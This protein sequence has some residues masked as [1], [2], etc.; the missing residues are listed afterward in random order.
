MSDIKI[1]VVASDI[2]QSDSCNYDY[3]TIYDGKLFISSF[4]SVWS[5]FVILIVFIT[6]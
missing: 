2:E 6:L 4:V 5:W 1:K 3:V